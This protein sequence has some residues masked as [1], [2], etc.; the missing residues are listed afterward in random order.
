MS[1]TCASAHL[2]VCVC[3]CVLCVYWEQG[4]FLGIKYFEVIN[5]HFLLDVAKAM[6]Q[7]APTEVCVG[8]ALYMYICIR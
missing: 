4:T 6:M 3:V 8:V 5:P 1:F 2:S 7:Y